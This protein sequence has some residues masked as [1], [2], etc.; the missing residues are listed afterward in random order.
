MRNV[1]SWGVYT[2]TMRSISEMLAT[3]PL[4]QDLRDE[5]MRERH[6]KK[7]MRTCGRTFVMDAKFCLRDLFGLQVRACACSNVYPV[8]ECHARASS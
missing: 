1:G 2:G 8:H 4:V 6:W 5:A 3:L 7:L